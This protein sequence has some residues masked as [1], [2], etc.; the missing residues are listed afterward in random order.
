MS[1]EL[2][3]LI[4]LNPDL[5]LEFDCDHIHNQNGDPDPDPPD[6]SRA[7]DSRR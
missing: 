5:D 1:G 2:D 6:S 4:D 7:V 3:L